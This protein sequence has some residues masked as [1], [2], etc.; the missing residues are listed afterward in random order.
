MA[1]ALNSLNIDAKNVEPPELNDEPPELCKFY[2]SSNIYQFCIST[3][4]FVLYVSA[5]LQIITI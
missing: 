1:G 4:A 3:S 5:L 2:N